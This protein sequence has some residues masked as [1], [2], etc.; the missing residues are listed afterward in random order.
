M[1]INIDTSDQMTICNLT[2][3]EAE[4]MK[5]RVRELLLASIVRE[6]TADSEIER[7]Q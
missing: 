6:Q 3:R 2:W 4:K 1:K 7:L 5:H